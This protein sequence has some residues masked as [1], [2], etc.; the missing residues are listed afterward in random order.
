MLAASLFADIS[1]L[2]DT[3]GVVIGPNTPRPEDRDKTWYKTSEDGRECLCIAIYTGDNSTSGTG[4]GDPTTCCTT[5]GWCCIFDKEVHGRYI[6]WPCDE[7]IPDGYQLVQETY[8]EWQDVYS[9]L[10]KIVQCKKQMYEGWLK[11]MR[12][13]QVS[14][15][16]TQILTIQWLIDNAGDET[17]TSALE[18]QIES[19]K[20]DIEKLEAIQVLKDMELPC[21]E[22]E[23]PPDNVL[24][25]LD[26]EIQR[27]TAA[28]ECFRLLEYRGT[29]ADETIT[30]ITPDN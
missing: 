9:C 8:V 25:L 19:L 5:G 29:A 3:R 6:M 20:E 15:V 30:D 7:D 24:D 1:K 4:Q 26:E 13:C 2:G 10:N 17:D 22:G 21:P 27:K 18:A 14:T 23:E 12:D 11:P 28:K 16:N